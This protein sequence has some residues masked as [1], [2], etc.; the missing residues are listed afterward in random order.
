MCAAAGKETDKQQLSYWSELFSVLCSL[1]ADWLLCLTLPCP[2]RHLLDIA[3]N[4]VFVFVVLC[5]CVEGG[6][7]YE[8]AATE[9]S[10][11]F[12]DGFDALF[13]PIWPRWWPNPSRHRRQ[14]KASLVNRE[15]CC[16]GRYLV[17]LWW[18]DIVLLWREVGERWEKWPY[19]CKNCQLHH[20][21]RFW[22]CT[23]CWSNVSFVKMC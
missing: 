22:S 12:D 11:R 20:D 8:V 4:I 3:V 23:S 21:P 19:F 6:G 17:L 5:V 9:G 18:P 10:I 15:G 14:R 1:F 16:R 2:S 13:M 7:Q